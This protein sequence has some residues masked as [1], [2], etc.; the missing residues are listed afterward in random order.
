[1]TRYGYIYAIYNDEIP[2]YTGKTFDMKER[3]RKHRNQHQNTTDAK[4]YNRKINVFLRKVG[5]DNCEM[6]LL[7]TI[8]IE[9]DSDLN[10]H[11]GRWQSIMEK[12]FDLLNS[13]KA[14]NGNNNDINSIAYQNKLI[15]DR[16]N[17]STTTTTHAPSYYHFRAI[18]EK[19]RCSPT[20]R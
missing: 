9:T 20:K 1:M 6:R 19:C 2:V 17:V 15:R 8:E 3:W 14:G 16:E 13:L 4:K 18:S 7:E 11:E 5:F 12:D 10:R